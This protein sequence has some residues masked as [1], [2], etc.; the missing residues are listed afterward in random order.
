MVS[1]PKMLLESYDLF[2]KKSLGQN[3]MHDPQALDK[4]VDSAA[5]TAADTVVEVGA[6]T[7]S[8]TAKLAEGCREVFAIEVDQRLQPVLEDR[9]DDVSNVYLVFDDVLKTDINTLMGNQEYVVVANLPYYISSAILWHFLEA[10]LP[11]RRMVLTMQYEVAERIVAGQ[12]VMNLLSVALQYYGAPQIVSKLSP[13]VF[14]PRPNIH[15]AIVRIETHERAPVAVPS[16][17]AFFRVVRAGFSM[18]R[19]Q[20]KNALSGGLGI[21]SARTSELLSAAG[22][23]PQRRAET[24]TLSEW[25][26]LTRSIHQ[27]G[28]VLFM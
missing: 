10:D 6:G 25:A 24:L 11:P 1:N 14:W 7:G 22:I 27:S 4:I 28:D 17:E 3:F 26:G 21:S 18:K 16:T 8:L 19:K 23:D 9:F 2:P 12:G 20:L 13:A 5:L 15:S